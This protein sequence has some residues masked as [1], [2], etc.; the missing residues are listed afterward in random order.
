MNASHEATRRTPEP[1]PASCA[2]CNGTLGSP[3]AFCPFCGAAQ[4]KAA[5]PP[6]PAP[7]P[8]PAPAAPV[9]TRLDEPGPPAPPP[10]SDVPPPQWTVQRRRSRWPAI[11]A[12]ACVLAVAALVNWLALAPAPVARLVVHVHAPN[13]A[14]LV[15]G[16]IVV[17]DR[18]VGIPGETLPVHPGS[19]TVRLDLP[20][21]R[22]DV[23]TVSVAR[24]ATL[25]VDL[26]AREL[27]ARLSLATSPPGAAIRIL[28]R[29]Y[30]QSPLNIELAPGSYEVSVAL[31]GFVPKSVPVTLA[32]G[33]ERSVSVDLASVP[34]PAPPPLR[35]GA[36]PFDR[37]VVAA[38]TAL[39]A[40]PAAGAAT[41]ATFPAVSGVQVQAQVA[42][43]G[44]WLQVR[45]AGR[46]GFLLA[47]EVEPWD[48]WAQRNI[49]TGP[50]AA[51]TSSLQIVIAGNLYPLFGVQVPE[52]GFSAVGLGRVAAN[53]SGLLKGVQVRC[54]PQET[55]SFQCKTLEG[56][57]IAELYLLN[58]GAATGEGALPYYFDAQRSAREKQKGLWSEL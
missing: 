23:Q 55:T 25:T 28:G 42:S 38:N 43:D 22:S 41:V 5:S 31:S 12:A 19:A 53:L 4:Q 30:G 21:W 10:P 29:L 44:T 18:Q 9:W 3:V 39:L 7:E 35:F 56:R 58:G 6:P 32:H 2:A 54:V 14:A 11:V 49:A 13:G 17:N 27:P 40:G 48:S 26:T 57:D 24:D 34:P 51:V 15:A 47:S 46:Q 50:V 36:A 37:G 8:P 20:G 1:G 33:E 52:R 45:A 16:H